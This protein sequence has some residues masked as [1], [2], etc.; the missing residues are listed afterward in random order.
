[1]AS[2]L[3]RR[4]LVKL[5]LASAG[6]P[7]FSKLM[8]ANAFAQDASAEAG[9]MGVIGGRAEGELFPGKGLPGGGQLELRLTASIYTSDPDALE[10]AQRMKPYDLESWVTSRRAWRSATRRRRRSSPP[11][12]SR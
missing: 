9:K 7:A 3:S 2:S 5:G 8:A 11:R 10:I 6:I 12:G 4:S 1:M